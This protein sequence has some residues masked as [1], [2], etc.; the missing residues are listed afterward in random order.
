M[1]PMTF[2]TGYFGMNTAALP[3]TSPDGLGTIASSAIIFVVGIVT[4]GLL[5]H[6][7]L[8]NRRER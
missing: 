8:R 6:L 7:L 3:L 1:L 5:R 2:V 4:A